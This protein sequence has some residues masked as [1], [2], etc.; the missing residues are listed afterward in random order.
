MSLALREANGIKE[1]SVVLTIETGVF[2]FRCLKAQC[3]VKQ[4]Y[5]MSDQSHFDTLNVRKDDYY[6][7]KSVRRW[8]LLRFG[9]GW[10]LK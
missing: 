5:G 1:G 4:D 6:M 3:C 9:L 2:F 10:P 8:L 7:C